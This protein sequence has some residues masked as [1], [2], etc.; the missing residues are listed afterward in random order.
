M[1]ISYIY[2]VL[3]NIYIDLSKAFDTLIHR[4]LLEKISYYDVNG[5]A[6]CLLQSYLAQKQQVVDFNGFISATLDIKIGVPQG[7]V[8]G[9]FL[10]QCILMICHH[11]N[12]YKLSLNVN[13]TKLMVFYSFNK[14]V[15]YPKL[16]I[17]AI[18]IECVDDF[19]FLGLQ[20]NHNLK[21]NKHI[22]YVSLKM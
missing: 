6:K 13:K 18:E 1:L 5:V 22:H 21:W 19:N 3:C 2:Y 8:L 17:D 14:T 16:R 4:I 11:I 9:S 7:S 10:F 20:L 15:L 12:Y